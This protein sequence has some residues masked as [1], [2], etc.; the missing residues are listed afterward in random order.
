[1]FFFNGAGILLVPLTVRL[2]MA[3]FG[4]N[5]APSFYLIGLLMFLPGIWM[6]FLPTPL[7]EEK[8]DEN[9]SETTGSNRWGSIVLVCGALIFGFYDGAT[10][11]FG[12]YVFVYAFFKL[13]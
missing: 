3:N 1:M 9:D 5:Y 4:D 13:D 7:Q 8:K 6:L 2:A 10:T 11:G 12:P